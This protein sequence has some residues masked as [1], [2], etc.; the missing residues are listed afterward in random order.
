[1]RTAR[2]GAGSARPREG[3]ALP[4][5]A[6]NLRQ[7]NSRLGLVFTFLVLIGNLA[8]LVRFKEDDLA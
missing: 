6:S 1:M 7:D 3:G 5:T 2:V 8:D 4:Y